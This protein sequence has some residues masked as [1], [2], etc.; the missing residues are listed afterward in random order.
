MKMIS[1]QNYKHVG[2]IGTIV[3][4]QMTDGR[5]YVERQYADQGDDWQRL[6]TG[7]ETEA[8]AR[9]AAARS[10]VD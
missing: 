3:L 7:D 9:Y 2:E 6:Y 10:S 1:L 8:R 5:W 4:Q